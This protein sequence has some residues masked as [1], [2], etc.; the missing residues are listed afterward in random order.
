MNF[1]LRKLSVDDGIDIYHMLQ[2]IPKDEN[3][4]I[5]PMN[6]KTFEEYKQWLI[7]SDELSKATELQDNWKV[8][9]TTYWL[10]VNGNPVGM[11]KIR[12]FLTDKLMEEGG[13]AGYA[14]RHGERNKGYG[15]IL[16]KM[17]TEEAL[18]IKIDRLLLTI[19]NNNIGSIKVALKN[20]G[21][22]EKV[23][24]ERHYIWIDC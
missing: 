11:G 18:E 21:V 24:A 20:N 16:L 22:I 14:I 13:N 8:P 17:L 10:Y 15:T 7:R 4:L 12:H 5:N 23:N 1:E 2:E 9:T 6:G 19:R 3:G